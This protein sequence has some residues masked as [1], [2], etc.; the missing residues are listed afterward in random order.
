MPSVA[1]GTGSAVF[2]DGMDV[3]LLRATIVDTDGN[4]VLDSTA[5]VTF[6][7]SSGP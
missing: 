2:A 6:T 4:T 3:A 7:V 5:N 1:T